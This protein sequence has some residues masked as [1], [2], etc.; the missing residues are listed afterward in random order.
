MQELK[1]ESIFVTKI[2]S[3]GW[4]F[5]GKS[6]WKNVKIGQSLFC[7]QETNKIVLMHDPY[8]VAWKLKSKGKLGADI[9]GHMPKEISWA[10]WFFLE[11]GRKINGKVF[12][13]KYRPSPVPKGGIKIMPSTKLRIVN[14]KGNI[15]ECFKEIIQSNYLEN[16]NTNSYQMN[17]LAVINVQNEGFRESQEDEEEEDH[18]I[19]KKEEGVIFLD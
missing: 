15:L 9:V 17:D 7:E 19:D 13:E 14:E 6:S 11:H 3:R 4:H 18:M 12:E 2:A 8:A 10:A 1:I 5:F 16:V